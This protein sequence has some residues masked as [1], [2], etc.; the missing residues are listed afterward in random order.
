MNYSP[1]V[2]VHAKGLRKDYG[3]DEGL[4]RALDMVDLDVNRGEAVA[5]MGPSGCGKQ[6]TRVI[7]LMALA[8]LGLSEAFHAH[9]P[10]LGVILLL[11]VTSATVPYPRTS[12]ASSST[13]LEFQAS[14]TPV[15]GPTV[16]Q[17]SPACTSISS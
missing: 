6:M 5:V 13:A 2:L 16:L 4:V 9:G 3:S 10:H 8:A 12:A 11:C 17:S 7:A 15:L 14:T 1:T